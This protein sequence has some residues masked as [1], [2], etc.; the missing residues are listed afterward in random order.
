MHD[1]IKRFPLDGTL[2]DRNIVSAKE[3]LVR[4][5]ETAMRDDGFVPV[6]DLHPHFTLDYDPAAES[7]QFTLSV[8]GSYVGED[9][10]WLVDGMMDGKTIMKSILPTKSKE[11]CVTPT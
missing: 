4:F 8:W 7:Y 3:R 9:K 5:Q 11:S 10:S 6:L 1:D 2:E